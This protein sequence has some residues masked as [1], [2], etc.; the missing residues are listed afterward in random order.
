MRGAALALVILALLGAGTWL[1]VGWRRRAATGRLETQVV[2]DVE[3]GGVDALV[4]AQVAGRRLVAETKGA[5]TGA[6]ALAFADATLAVEYGFDTMGEAERL[7][8]RLPPESEAEGRD[9][10]WSMEAAARALT[11]VQMGKP[12]AAIA[13]AIR[14]AA[15]APGTAYPLYALGRAR[16]RTGDLVA[17]GRALEAGMVAGPGFGPVRTALA[18]VELDLGDAKAARATLQAILTQAPSDLQAQLLL[19][20]AETALDADVPIPEPCG[21]AARADADADASTTAHPGTGA[22]DPARDAGP[23]EGGGRS[24]DALPAFFRAGCA[25]G[26]AV[27]A[28]RAGDRTRATALAAEAAGLVPDVPRL[29]A[30]VAEALAQLGAVDLAATLLERA[31]PS[32]DAGTPAYAWAAAAVALGRGRAPSLPEG[33]RPADPETRLL[34][35]RAALAAG[36]IGELTQALDALGTEALAHDADLRLYARLRATGPSKEDSG[37]TDS[38]ATD[39]PLAAYVDGLRAQLRGDLPA[40][41]ERFWHALSGHGDACRAVG[42]YVATL[43]A[44]KLPADPSAWRALPAQNAGCKNLH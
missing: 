28:R 23:R 43:R 44:L 2:L 11:L 12:T 24:T 33:P 15:A 13:Q 42:E 29:L 4:R 17:A 36:G 32:I 14:A 31:R 26:G 27:R 8:A 30:R 38:D 18:E 20:E 6:T 3:R 40:A 25:L 34:V 5:R 22:G 21:R 10:R 37:R 39:D 9:G 16:T 7:L 35:A 1:T 41:V 19:D